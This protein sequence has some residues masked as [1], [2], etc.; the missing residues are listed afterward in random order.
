MSK[1]RSPAPKKVRFIV[2]RIPK[3]KVSLKELMRIIFSDF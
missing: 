3:L 2:P 1:R